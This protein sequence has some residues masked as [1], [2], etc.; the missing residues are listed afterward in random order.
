[1]QNELV[2]V[3]GNELPLHFVLKEE[4]KRGGSSGGGVV[5]RPPVREGGADVK[6][7]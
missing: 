4:D 2:K 6:L 1:M 7:I 3:P 5:S